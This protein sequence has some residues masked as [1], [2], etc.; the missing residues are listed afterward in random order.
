MPEVQLSAPI[1]NIPPQ[2][3]EPSPQEKEER[4]PG[5]LSWLNPLNRSKGDKEEAEDKKSPSK[6]KRKEEESSF[7][8]KLIPF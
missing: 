7:F 4:K 3:L 5:L 8:G 1:P 2:A 6:E